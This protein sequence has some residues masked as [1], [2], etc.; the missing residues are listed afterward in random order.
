[1]NKTA[2]L[3]VLTLF[4]LL[5]CVA[6][7]E[8]TPPLGE[9]QI[10]LTSVVI[11]ESLT[12]RREPGTTAKAVKTLKYGT[13]IIVINQADG[14]AYCT[15]GDSEDSPKGW[16]NADYLI[17]DPAWY[18]T[19]E[20]T[21]VYAWN[22][23]LAPKVA[24]LDAGTSL[25]IL[26]AEGEWLIVSLRGA[27]G[28]I[29]SAEAAAYS[30]SSAERYEGVITIEGFE[31]TVRYERVKNEVIGI[32][33]DYDYERL[34]RRSETGVERFI[35]VYD[36]PANPENYFEIMYTDEAPDSVLAKVSGELSAD[37]DIIVE[38]YTL[39]RAGVCTRVDASVAK[40]GKGTPDFLRTVYIVPAGDGCVVVN[41]YYGFEAAEGFGVRFRNMLDTLAF[42]Y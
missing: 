42:L 27:T 39:A 6:H 14:W 4:A 19:E 38:P 18:K 35:S 31:E 32:E 29:K 41:A 23:T 1:M 40:G 24:L 16:V 9:G 25:P 13:R 2:L 11:C 37:Y 22:D 26:K 30:S 15:L 12:L 33:I 8:I 20:K 36:D 34:A 10:G 5:L 21:P 3:A 28:W 7:A 17:I